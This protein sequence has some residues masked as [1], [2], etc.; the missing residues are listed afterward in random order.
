MCRK[1]GYGLSREVRSG[2]GQYQAGSKTLNGIQQIF[3]K[4]LQNVDIF[5]ILGALSV[6]V[7]TP[8]RVVIKFLPTIYLLNL[9][10]VDVNLNTNYVQVYE[11]AV[12]NWHG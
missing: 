10:K 2:S 8:K 11:L 3:K 5:N 1:Y 12:E 9:A 6:T 4:Y 7:L